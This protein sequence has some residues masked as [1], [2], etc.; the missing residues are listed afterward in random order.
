MH[1]YLFV[2]QF[3]M[4]FKIAFDMLCMSGSRTHLLN[5]LRVDVAD[6]NDK[7]VS[8][9]AG[10]SVTQISLNRCFRVGRWL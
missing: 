9:V 10:K 3:F 4:T 8:K 6:G 2:F 1:I 5:E 7:W